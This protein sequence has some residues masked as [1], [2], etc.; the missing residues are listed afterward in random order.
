MLDL[1][2]L[3]RVQNLLVAAVGVLAGGWI[4][5]GA[6]VT[7][8]VLALA[9][10]AAVGFGAAGNAL[11]DLWDS[12]ADRINR[13]G[14]ERP[15]ASGR[16]ARGTADLCVA[17]GTLLGFAAAAL[18]SGTA[19]LVGAAA[20]AVLALYSPVLKARGFPGNLAVAIIAGLPLEYG[21]IA[22][23]HAA[24]G[25]VP[26]ILAGWIHLV[27]EIVKDVDDQEGDRAL[28]RR[29]LPLVLGPRRATVIA[30][31]LAAVFVPLSLALPAW[32]NYRGAYFLIALFAQLV[33]LAVASRLFSGRIKGN[34]RLLKGAMLVGMVALVAGRVI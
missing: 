24:A 20:L 33:V 12:A 23:G 7:P 4:G 15:L 26:W 21:A 19:V 30:A 10:L 16:L 28:G 11:N 8:G 5:L 3:V 18:V 2:R 29:T 13:P 9:A 1:L 14:G 25:I 31:V 17:G 27:R 6:L 22:V 32:A 34:S